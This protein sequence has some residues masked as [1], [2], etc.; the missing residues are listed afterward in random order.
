MKI[1]QLINSLQTGGAEKLLLE[2]IPLFN[3]NEDISVDLAIL[4]N[5]KA[6]FLKQLQKD[7]SLQIFI[8][9]KKNPY[10]PIHIIKIISLL[11]RYDIVH[12]HLFPSL[13]WASLAKLF[14]FS[15]TKLIY[16]E[17][18]TSNRR[19]NKL[20]FKILDKLIY[21]LYS[22]IITISPD[23]EKG[24]KGHLNFKEQKFELIQNGV[25]IKNIKNE[26]PYLKHE[27]TEE[28]SENNKILVQ[29]SSFTSQKDQE[30]LIKSLQ[31]LNSDI[32]LLLIGDGPLK[33]SCKKLVEGL[34]LT[35]RVFFLGIR[36]D[37]PKI[38]KT[39]DIVILSSHY[40]GLSLASIEGLASG[41]PF[42]ASDVP[43][44]KD[45][46]KGAGL[47]FPDKD[48]KMLSKHINDLLNNKSYYNK[49]A[50]KCIDRADKYDIKNTI[51]KQVTL[52]RTL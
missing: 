22:K 14:S 34:Q 37:V 6:P 45:I 10:N 40:E 23:V 51:E 26:T 19:R 47:L 7:N 43:G 2:S 33:A 4:N 15:K 1:L 32:V 49:I 44:L 25:N 39:A 21:S 13:Y 42:I 36:M 52:Y 11:K 41:K 24:I 9:S 31:L 46:V 35:D 17:H 38:L 8:L 28:I 48:F 16:T 3:Q 5:A 27:L 18:N 30:T 29:V 50:L 20:V 12:V